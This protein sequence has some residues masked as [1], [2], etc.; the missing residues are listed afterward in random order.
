MAATGAKPA[1]ADCNAVS[2]ETVKANAA[3][4]EAVGAT[5]IDGGIIGPPPHRGVPRLYVS[6]PDTTPIEAVQGDRLT[7]VPVCSPAY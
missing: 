2:P 3:L 6:G 1:F 5:F 7:V 4:F